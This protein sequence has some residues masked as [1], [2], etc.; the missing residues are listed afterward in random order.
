[1]TT[2]LEDD[3]G[4]IAELRVALSEAQSE[5][6]AL[7]LQCAMLRPGLP[8]HMQTELQALRSAIDGQRRDI[9]R[10]DQLHARREARL[11]LEIKLRDLQLEAPRTVPAR[12]LV[13]LSSEIASV[14]AELAAWQPMGAEPGQRASV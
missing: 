6:A 11:L 10:Q 2:V 9:L 4:E 7:K 12:S 5:I 8:A 13:D 14:R 3:T 1:M